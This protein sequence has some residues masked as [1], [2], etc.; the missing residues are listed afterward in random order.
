MQK[1]R[2]PISLLVLLLGIGASVGAA[3]WAGHREATI[4]APAAAE[5]A[6]TTDGRE[7]LY[8]RHPMGLPDTSPEPK[9]DSMGM[10]YIAV[11]ADEQDDDGTTV[12]VSLDKIQRSGVKTE[13]VEMR[14]LSRAIRGVGTVHHDESRL[15]IVTVRSDGYVE[16]LFVNKTGQAVREGEGSEPSS[17]SPMVGSVRPQRRLASRVTASQRSSTVRAGRAP[18]GCCRSYSWT[19]H[20]S[21]NTW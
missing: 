9:K 11:Y 12:K 18:R 10:D 3:Y 17:L 21:S 5:Q 20:C 8:Y 1:M 13:K 2:R 15:W 14:S 4:A 6:S 19:S 7:I 16:D